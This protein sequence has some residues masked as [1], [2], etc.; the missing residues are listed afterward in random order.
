[1]QTE[2][3]RFKGILNAAA[4][5]VPPSEVKVSAHARET[6]VKIEDHKIKIEESEW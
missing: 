3:N 2:N 5:I 4:K 6:D 1:M